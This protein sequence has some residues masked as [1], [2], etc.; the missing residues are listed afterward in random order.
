MSFLNALNS[1]KANNE[2]LGDA[3]LIDALYYF[4]KRYKPDKITQMLGEVRDTILFLPVRVSAMVALRSP[5]TS[6][7]RNVIISA[8]FWRIR[9]EEPNPHVV[10]AS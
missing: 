1:F 6:P 5:Q 9:R 2:R 10:M 4:Q 3:E 7:A 8:M